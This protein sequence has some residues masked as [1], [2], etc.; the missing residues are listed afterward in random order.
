[1]IPRGFIVLFAFVGF[2]VAFTLTKI[3]AHVL[4]DWMWFETLGYATAYKTMTFARFGSFIGF[5]SLFLLFATANIAIARK[6]GHRTRE[7]P[8]EV[9]VGDAPPSGILE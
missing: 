2:A 6:F 9:V 4:T 7:M 3:A 8:L 5:G 1:M